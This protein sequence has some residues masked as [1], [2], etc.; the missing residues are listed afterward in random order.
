MV[1]SSCAVAVVR[2]NRAQEPANGDHRGAAGACCRLQSKARQVLD[3]QR[4]W[5][6]VTGRRQ[7]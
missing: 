4:R 5:D 7:A 3:L 2:R 6:K 1:T